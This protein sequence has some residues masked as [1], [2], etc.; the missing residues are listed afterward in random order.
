MS[1]DKAV[2][3]PLANLDW[4]QLGRSLAMLV[5]TSVMLRHASID[6]TLRH[7]VHP[8]PLSEVDF[9]KDL[10]TRPLKEVITKWYGSRDNAATLA[11]AVMDNMLDE[12]A[13]DELGDGDTAAD[14]G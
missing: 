14:H 9:I 10:F 4:E 12:L 6:S 3:V 8:E 1:H 13:P 5:P 7:Y 11:A 2:G